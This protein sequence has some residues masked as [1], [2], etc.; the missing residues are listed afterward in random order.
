MTCRRSFNERRKKI[1]WFYFFFFQQKFSALD[2]D[3]ILMY[4][5]E[6]KKYLYVFWL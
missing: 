5:F 3:Q 1:W 2:R 6:K 4:I